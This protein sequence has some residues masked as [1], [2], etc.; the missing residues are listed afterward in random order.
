MK[1]FLVGYMGVGKTLYGKKLAAE[2]GLRFIDLDEYISMIEQHSVSAIFATK[3]EQYFRD[4]E[5]HC[6]HEICHLFDDFV[7]STGGGTPCFGDNMEYMNEQGHTIF[8]NADVDTIVGRLSKHKLKRPLL[9][10]LNDTE[11]RD[12]VVT[13]LTERMPYYQQAKEMIM[14]DKLID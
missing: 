14:N 3:G 8:V 5:L 10:K 2:W 13:H 12:F 7:L 11:L 9:S 4:L 6:L 1:Y